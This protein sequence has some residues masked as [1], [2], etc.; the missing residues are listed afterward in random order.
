MFL[1]KSII[2]IEH[3]LSNFLSNGLRDCQTRAAVI[4]TDVTDT[5]CKWINGRLTE[6]PTD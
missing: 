2:I 6:R 1:I 5:S 4:L 3:H